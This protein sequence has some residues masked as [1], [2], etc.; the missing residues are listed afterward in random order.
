MPP[1]LTT[2]NGTG[3]I[4][5]ADVRELIILPLREQSVAMQCATVITTGAHE[6]HFPRQTSEIEAQWAEEGAEL[7]V[8]DISF[9]EVTVRPSKVGAIT[10]A[11]NELIADSSPEAA[12]LVGDSIAAALVNAVDKAFFGA[13]PAPAPSGLGAL[14]DDDVILIGTD[15][16][17]LDPFAKAV[18]DAAQVGATLTS[19]VMNPATALTYA[20]LREGE[21]SERTLLGVDPAMPTRRLIEGRPILET[22]HV[23]EGLVW[24]VPEARAYVVLREDV[25]VDTS[26]DAAFSRDVTLLRG[27]LRIGFALDTAPG[28]VKIADISG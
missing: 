8:D 5:P 19:W 9:D 22:R 3:A 15:H 23:P 24:G 16:S 13:L 18:S 14:A 11:S 21:G 28:L 1:M 2:T 27:T 26:R 10:S 6:V 7:A 25:Q 17:G 4:L 20:L 12:A